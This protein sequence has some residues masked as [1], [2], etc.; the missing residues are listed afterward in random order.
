MVAEIFSREEK[1]IPSI[2]NIKQAYEYIDLR[3]DGFI[4]IKEWS[5][6]IGGMEVKIK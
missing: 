5:K 3:K 1:E 2:K 4:D 6:V